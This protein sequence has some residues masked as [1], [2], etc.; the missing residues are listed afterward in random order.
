M[1]FDRGELSQF[2]ASISA[3]GE[4]AY[5]IQTLMEGSSGAVKNAY[6]LIHRDILW[7]IQTRTNKLWFYVSGWSTEKPIIDSEEISDIPA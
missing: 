6:D 5:H 1:S 2:L 4:R 3:L 7:K